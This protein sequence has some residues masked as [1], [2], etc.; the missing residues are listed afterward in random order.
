MG[1]SGRVAEG[2]RSRHVRVNIQAFHTGVSPEPIESCGE[3]A[4]RRCGDGEGRTVVRERKG[5]PSPSSPKSSCFDDWNAGEDPSSAEEAQ[6]KWSE[7]V[8]LG[9]HETPSGIVVGERPGL[10]VHEP[11]PFER[12]DGERGDL[13]VRRRR[14]RSGRAAAQAPRA[15]SAVTTSPDPVHRRRNRCAERSSRALCSAQVPRLQREAQQPAT[16]AE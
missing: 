9:E 12:V 4:R 10:R 16:V 15:R 5:D 6:R 13:S 1:E 11:F 14:V 8:A 7:A 3:F 2:R